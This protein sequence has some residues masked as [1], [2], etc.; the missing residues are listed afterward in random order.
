MQDFVR[1]LDKLGRDIV[2][3]NEII[4]QDFKNAILTGKHPHGSLLPTEKEIASQYGVSRVPVQQALSSLKNAG[5]I[6]R[7][8]GVGTRVLY[9][10][11]LYCL[12]N[13]NTV[14]LFNDLNPETARI[15]EGAQAFLHDKGVFV[16][17]KHSFGDP[18]IERKI[19]NQLL[20]DNIEGLLIYKAD[21]YT[22]IDLI[23]KLIIEEKSLIFVDNAP[24][25]MVC[26]CIMSDPVLSMYSIV[27]HLY[28]N[29]HR[30]IGVISHPLDERSAANIRYKMLRMALDQF[31]IEFDERYF[32][33]LNDDPEY[34]LNK[35]MNLNPP[36]TALI[37]ISMVLAAASVDAFETLKIKIPEDL[38]I[39]GHDNVERFSQAFNIDLT[40]VA[41]NYY[42]IGSIAASRLF[43]YMVK[44]EKEFKIEY[45]PSISVITPRVV[46]SIVI[47][48][49]GNGSPC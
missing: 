23:Y 38:S 18:K 6:E 35:M 4:F 17:I 12:S 49:P 26:N 33:E 37:F 43:E 5:Y 42:E 47:V 28:E 21:S 16:S 48:T 11:N 45:V 27:K 15:A 8:A 41:Q 22:N 1:R 24:N 19:L 40:S 46:P 13:C 25:D 44:P 3:K 9:K 20:E 36:P 2:K 7:R 30:R 39:I 32:M 14:F 31:K 10:S 34:I 29:G